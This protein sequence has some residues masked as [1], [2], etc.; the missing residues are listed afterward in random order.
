MR[1]VTAVFVVVLAAAALAAEPA[2]AL[3]TKTFQSPSA[4]IGCVLLLSGSGNEARCDVAQHTW[5]APPKPASCHLDFGNGLVVGDK[6]RAQFVCAGD[7][8]L[9]QGP[10]LAYGN[11]IRLGKFR[12]TSKTSGMRCVNRANGHGFKASRTVARRF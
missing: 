12:C 11:S 8:V 7:T 10:T 9:H 4:N 1:R 5:K 3:R 6:G 2:A